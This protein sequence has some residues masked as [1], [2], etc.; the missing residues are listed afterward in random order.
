MMRKILIV[1]DDQKT[2]TLLKAY[3]E[4]NQY[5]V[6]LAHNGESFLAEF[7]RYIDE[8][9]IVILDVMLPDTDGFA[10]CKTVRHRSNVPI[11]MLTA[12]SDETDRIVGLE[13]GAD[14]YI[15]KP[16]SPRELLARIKAIHRRT[17]IENTSAPR[18]YRFVGFTLD[19]VE[20]SVVDAD[21]S[22]VTLTG[23]DFQ[24]LKYFVE[25][26]GDIL[27]RS[28]LCEETRGRDVGP[29]DR[30]LDVQISRLR[31]RLHDD[32]KQP[33]L[34]KTVRGAGYVFSADVSVSNV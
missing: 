4:K 11:I 10:L 17:G 27:D 28:V 20:R 29:L 25:H 24:L 7:Q 19:T 34:I 30:S 6:R 2:R 21:G 14:D 22:P 26:P 33:I 8:L 15:A 1:D 31:L 32:G 18:F 3:L 9:S 13:L 23:M 5:E 16:Y 12:S